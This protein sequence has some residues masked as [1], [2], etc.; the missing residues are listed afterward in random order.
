MTAANVSLFRA[1][2]GLDAK[3]SERSFCEDENQINRA[4]ETV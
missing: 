3:F 2:F 4:K 1:N